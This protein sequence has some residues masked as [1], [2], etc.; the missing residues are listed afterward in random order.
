MP[1]AP[2]QPEP[3]LTD[4]ALLGMPSLTSHAHSFGAAQV[5]AGSVRRDPRASSSLAE[6]TARATVSRVHGAELAAIKR[7]AK[8]RAA[9]RMAAEEDALRREEE[10]AARAREAEAAKAAAAVKL[11]IGRA[12]V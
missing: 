2:D 8:E 3:G 4:P 1:L 6:A 11:Q 7:A 9:A 10:E 12:H 5:L